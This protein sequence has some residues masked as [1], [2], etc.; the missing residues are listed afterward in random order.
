MSQATSRPQARTDSQPLS[1]E[2]GLIPSFPPRRVFDENGRY[3]P[4]PPEE[5]EAREEAYRRAMKV[6]NA[7]DRD[8]P[9]SDEE[10]MRGIDSHRPPGSKLFEGY[11]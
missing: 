8:P 3:I 5:R 4:M 9:E 11:Y 1:D 6:I 7:T 10:F 2:Q